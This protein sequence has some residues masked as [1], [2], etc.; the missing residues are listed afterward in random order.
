MEE[1]FDNNNSNSTWI[2]GKY[3]HQ[4]IYTVV[5]VAVENIIHNLW[6]WKANKLDGGGGKYQLMDTYI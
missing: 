6:R 2:W 4:N 5:M 3:K 1:V